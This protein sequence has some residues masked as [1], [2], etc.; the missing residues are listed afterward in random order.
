MVAFK[1][2]KNEVEEKKEEKNII[3]YIGWILGFF[4]VVA[5]ILAMFAGFSYIFS[6][7]YNYSFA[8]VYGGPTITWKQTLAGIGVIW[9]IRA[10]FSFFSKD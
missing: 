5:A 10:I 8:E 1:D 2:F 3:F 6:I 4:M 9:L 7:A